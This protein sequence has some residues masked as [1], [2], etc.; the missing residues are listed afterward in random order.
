MYPPNR[1]W[2][3]GNSH[4][5]GVLTEDNEALASELCVKVDLLKELSKNI[6]QEVREQNGFLDG[7]LSDM[8]TR[9]EN[10][11]RRA[12]TRVGIIK[13]DQGY[14]GLGLYCQL[15]LFAFLFFF[16][17]SELPTYQPARRLR[18]TIITFSLFV[19]LIIVLDAFINWNSKRDE[20]NFQYEIA[21]SEERLQS[22]YAQFYLLHEPA[23]F[24]VQVTPHERDVDLYV[25]ANEDLNYFKE[26]L[27]RLKSLLTSSTKGIKGADSKSL[28]YKLDPPQTW[29]TIAPP[30]VI[31]SNRSHLENASNTM[32][33]SSGPTFTISSSGLGVEVVYVSKALERPLLLIVFAPSGGFFVKSAEPSKGSEDSQYHHYTIQIFESSEEV[34]STYES[35]RAEAEKRSLSYDQLASMHSTIREKDDRMYKGNF[36]PSHSLPKSP[37]QTGKEEERRRETDHK[38]GNTERISL[39]KF[40]LYEFLEIL[41]N[42]II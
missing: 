9:S 16:L 25:V 7:S 12:L 28:I 30:D 8:L 37:I 31:E 13:R 21:S 41:L 2:N 1:T 32:Y 27:P 17:Y 35:V 36:K 19:L 39:T 22:G 29:E 11:I 24:W 23:S 5:R 6:G 18:L 15:F 38:E 20:D 33:W 3:N 42:A 4:R 26:R 14:C 10:G 34:T 40:F